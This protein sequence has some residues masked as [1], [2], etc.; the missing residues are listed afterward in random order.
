[1][2]ASEIRQSFLSFFEG[3][4]H[5]A[6][7]SSSLVPEGDKTLMFA[8]AGM[9]QFKDIFT[10]QTP[11]KVPCATTSQKCVRAGGKHNDLENVGKTARHHTFFEML[12]NFSFGDYFKQGAIE[13][14]WSFLTET[15][16]LEKE[17]LYITIHDSDDEAGEIWKNVAGL[18][19]DRIVKMGDK[20]NFWAM[21]D[22][23]PCGPC[24]EIH[25]D[26]GSGVGCGRAEC[27]LY[28]DC[29]RYLEIWNLVFMQ[30]E[31]K[32]DG[33]RLPLPNPCIDT[34]MGLERLAAVVN[35]QPSNYDTDLFIPLL[36]KVA[37][38]TGKAYAKGDGGVSH[39]V[40]ADHGKAATFL[41]TDGILP[42]NEGRGYVLRRIMRRAIRHSWL[43]GYREPILMD[44]AQVSFEL[45]GEAYPALL[46]KKDRTLQI[47]EREEQGFLKTIEKGIALFDQSRDEWKKAG[48]VPGDAAFKLYDTFGF[49]L[50][51][52]EVMAEAEGLGIDAKG[53]DTCMEEQ[54][55]KARSA[56]MFKTG[57]LAGLH[58]N[59][60][61]EG[62]QSFSG[63]ESLAGESSV[64][65]WSKT[66]EG[67]LLLVPEACV[68]YGES[69]G[70]VGDSGSIEIDGNSISVM[71]CQIVEGKR[72]LILDPDAD[73]EPTAD[74]MIMQKVDGERR[75]KIQANHTCT[76][77]LHKALKDVIGEHAEQRGSWVGPTHLRFDFPHH[78]AVSKDQL[79]DVEAR[80]NG[81]IQ[82]SR[83]VGDHTTSLDEAKAQGVTALF[84]EKY[85]DTVRVVSVEEESVELCGGTH[86]SNTGEAMAFVIQGESS[87]ASGIR[88]IEA[89]TGKAAIDQLFS[90]R[91]ELRE[92]T[93]LAQAQPGALGE[94]ISQLQEDH[95]VLRKEMARV[96]REMVLGSLEQKM[97]DLPMVG[98]TPYLAEILEG[99]EAGDLRT[100]AEAV[101]AKH[102]NLPILLACKGPGRAN[103]LIAFPKTWVKEKGVNAGKILKPLG[104]HIQGGGGG[105]P[106]LAQAGGKNPDGLPD[107][108]KGFKEALSELLS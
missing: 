63:Y 74:L 18:P 95:Q 14:A 48:A 43:L 75:T 37:E 44:L 98:D 78:E 56:S 61:K 86:L 27:D 87:V 52:T 54:R 25:F 22:T 15:M 104:K 91:Q 32:A 8:N 89:I 9:N 70:Q 55:E 6:M 3:K 30:F 108:L 34:G 47:I 80:V 73:L 84:G 60:L 102:D 69:G 97:A 50:D 96:K 62:E 49:P 2:N 103:V 105:S 38:L 65:T 107:V 66:A 31:Q 68:F 35:G 23:G 42:S 28:C 88:R 59:A 12:G 1:M 85:G 36:E 11:R 90:S 45:Y 17:K 24:S 57:Q 19:S 106:D 51:L 41:I 81:M 46:E 7:P 58:W 64:L 94:R 40:L 33:S 10:G 13:H 20:D 67:Q 72:T 39:R 77:L 83:S 16:K 99:A 53:F 26:Q 82:Q 29:D 92:A 21:G 76:H 93:G 5:T 71:D 79:Q 101:R 4:G 100:A